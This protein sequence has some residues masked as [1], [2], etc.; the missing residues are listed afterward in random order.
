VGLGNQV[1][2]VKVQDY[3]P[4]H[5]LRIVMELDIPDDPL[6]VSIM[7]DATIDFWSLYRQMLTSAPG[8]PVWHVQDL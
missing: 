3:L 4:Y 5:L 8:A 7:F 2:L 1:A 6:E